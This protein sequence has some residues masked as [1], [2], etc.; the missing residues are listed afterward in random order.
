MKDGSR[1]SYEHV[2]RRTTGRRKK[3]ERTNV[4]RCPHPARGGSD[5]CLFHLPVDEKDAATVAGALVAVANDPARPSAFIG[6]QFEALSVASADLESDAPLDLRGSMIHHDLDLRDA[7]V[8]ARLRL[9]GVSVGGSVFMDRFDARKE[10]TCR[11]IQIGGRWVLSEATV[12]GRLDATDF[13]A[14][15]LIATDA[16]FERGVTFRRG[17]VE[18]ALVVARATFDGPAWFSHTHIG[19]HLDIGNATCERRLSLAHCRVAGSV[20]AQSTTVGNGLSL[21]HVHVGREFDAERLTVAGG[22]DA[23][24]GRFDGDVDC[25]GLTCTD[26]QVEFDH[27]TFRGAAHFDGATITGRRLSFRS[28]RFESG[29]VSFVRTAVS[30]DFDL[31]EV[32][33]SATAAVRVVEGSVGGSVV[34][35]HATFE[36]ELFLSAMRVKRDFDFSDCTVGMLTFGVEVDG[37][38]NFAYTHVT[39]S[40]GF[41][42]TVVHGPAR[43][44]NARFDTDPSLTDATVDGSIAAYNLSVMPADES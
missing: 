14:D 6:G 2:S 18:S 25:A 32:T 34:C 5:R 41:R 7:T 28:A 27:S 19:G 29:P 12:G 31:S 36:G 35:N 1:C 38:L 17:S 24:T 13:G 8:D 11:R 39:D 42:E 33:S 23:T 22:I 44:T 10:V 37:R 16:T 26:G 43:F 21:D 40:A 20:T 15:S 4:W 9:D 3:D 30:G